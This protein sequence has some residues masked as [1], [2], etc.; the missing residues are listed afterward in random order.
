MD[1]RGFLVVAGAALLGPDALGRSLG[2]TPVALVTAD[3]ESRIAA[4]EL[5]TGKRLASIR[6]M[7]GPRSIQTVGNAAVVAHTAHGAV[8]IVDGAT[9]S[10]RR[11]LRDFSEPRYAAGLH[12]RFAF[13]TDSALGR[14]VV[15]D[16]VRGQVVGRIE[17]GGPARHVTVDARR[18][19]V[20]A[21]LGTKASRIAVV[22]VSAPAH[23]RLLGRIR[24]PFLAHD[25]GF[26][27]D[28]D[29]SGS[30]PAAVDGRRSSTDVLSARSRCSTR[31][32]P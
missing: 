18:G 26:A 9:L 29:A 1:R 27:P 24:P 23:P 4:V 11:V 31:A 3:L 2:G 14:L 19:V 6:T 10:V 25:V 28:G 13:V 15:V 8:S 20:W 17:L 22:D 30:R 21:A 7:P 16:V 5:S 32:R 12:G